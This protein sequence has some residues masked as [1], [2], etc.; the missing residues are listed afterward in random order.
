MHNWRKPTHTHTREHLN[1]AYK[2]ANIGF[3]FIFMCRLFLSGASYIDGEIQKAKQCTMD[4]WM[5]FGPFWSTAL[6]E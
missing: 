1:D 5:G 6:P 3:I 4:G 2:K